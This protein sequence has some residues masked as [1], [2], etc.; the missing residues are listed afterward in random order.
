MCRTHHITLGAHP[1]TQPVYTAT[2]KVT[3][4][5]VT[6]QA[7]IPLGTPRTC[8]ERLTTLLA[9]SDT[10]LARRDIVVVERHTFVV[11]N[12]TRLA[13]STIVGV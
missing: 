7:G 11:N 9:H 1:K 10:S 4:K 5:S 13:E 3:P 12:V 8:S 2:V 6:V